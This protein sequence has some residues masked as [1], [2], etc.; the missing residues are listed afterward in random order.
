VAEAEADE[1]PS[2]RREAA[3]ILAGGAARLL[4]GH[5]EEDRGFMKKI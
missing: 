4:A 1:T 5:D 2:G 3:R